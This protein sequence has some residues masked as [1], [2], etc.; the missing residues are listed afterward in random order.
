MK[1]FLVAIL[2]GII[3]TTAYAAEDTLQD[4]RLA[5]TNLFVVD[6]SINGQTY[7]TEVNFSDPLAVK[8]AIDRLIQQNGLASSD[9]II[10]QF[11]EQA[12]A[13]AISKELT[14]L[15]PS[16][17]GRSLP[18]LVDKSN[19]AQINTVAGGLNNLGLTNGGIESVLT[20]AGVSAESITIALNTSFGAG[21]DQPDIAD[22][23]PSAGGTLQPVVATPDSDTTTVSSELQIVND[24]FDIS[25]Q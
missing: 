3:Q 20:S 2:L 16:V 9:A 25:P 14:L 7:T 13:L 8:N 24:Q 12:Q 17:D 19:Q 10:Q 4:N 15:I 18:L 23:Q 5:Q 1:Q 11:F 21:E 22:V 6:I